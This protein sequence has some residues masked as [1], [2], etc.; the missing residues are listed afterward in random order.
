MRHWHYSR[1]SRKALVHSHK[2]GNEIHG[3]LNRG[4]VGYGR[5][6]KSLMDGQKSL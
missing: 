1:P 5:T 2:G 6:K 4:W 3:H